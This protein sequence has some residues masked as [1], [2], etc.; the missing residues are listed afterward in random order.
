LEGSLYIAIASLSEKS[1][2]VDGIPSQNFLLWKLPIY[3]PKTKLLLS[4]M[5]RSLPGFCTLR[6]EGRKVWACELSSLV[7]I[8]DTL[9]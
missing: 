4:E 9:Q 6:I 3:L 1:K 5:H 8:A 7:A 2:D